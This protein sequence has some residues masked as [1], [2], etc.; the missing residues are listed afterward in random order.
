MF[1]FSNIAC[2]SKGKTVTISHT[3]RKRNSFLIENKQIIQ[4]QRKFWGVNFQNLVNFSKIGE[5]FGKIFLVK[6]NFEN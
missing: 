3:L 6:K 4:R 1:L 5:V 2:V